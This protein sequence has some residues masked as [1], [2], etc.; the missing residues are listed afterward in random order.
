MVFLVYV[1]EVF[2]NEKDPYSDDFLISKEQLD[3]L[4]DMILDRIRSAHAAD[5]LLDCKNPLY[6]LAR[7]RS[8]LPRHPNMAR[9]CIMHMLA[10]DKNL[11]KICREFCNRFSY[12]NKMWNGSMG[13]DGVYFGQEVEIYEMLEDADFRN[14]L[15]YA[16]D[17]ERSKDERDLIQDA[18]SI[19]DRAVTR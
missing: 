18:I 8:M 4:K 15:D 17:L 11:V 19:W 14:V 16:N 3:Q 2:S 10:T 7:W 5:T 12:L 13:R 1:F 6:V 9:S